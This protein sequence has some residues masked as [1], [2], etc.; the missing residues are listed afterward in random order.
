[1]LCCAALCCHVLCCSCL[2]PC[3]LPL[4]VHQHPP[5][6]WA[7][8]NVPRLHTRSVPSPPEV[9]M[10]VSS[11][12]S[13]GGNQRRLMW[14][15]LIVQLMSN[16]ICVPHT[17]AMQPASEWSPGVVHVV[18]ESPSCPC[19]CSAVAFQVNGTLAA[20]CCHCD[21]HKLAA[22]TCTPGHATIISG[23]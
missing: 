7:T 15:G 12:C 16:N 11:G 10:I 5:G 9:A 18:V 1:M 14:L 13:V 4:C 2:L 17:L 19:C 22:H 6:A 20:T 23:E 8:S 21:T 3:N